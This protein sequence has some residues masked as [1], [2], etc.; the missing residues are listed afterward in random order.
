METILIQAT[1]SCKMKLLVWVFFLTVIYYN[2]NKFKIYFLFWM[3]LVKQIG[4][5][6]LDTVMLEKMFSAQLKYNL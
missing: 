3:C 6:Y 5:E 2:F 4:I 1:T